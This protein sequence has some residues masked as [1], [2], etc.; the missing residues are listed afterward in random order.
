MV[1]LTQWTGFAYLFPRRYADADLKNV[2]IEHWSKQFEWDQ[3]GWNGMKDFLTEPEVTLE[4]QSGDC[5]DFAFVIV[6]H[7]LAND[8]PVGI[9]A[10]WEKGGITPSHMVAYDK[11]CVY[12]S[13]NIHQS[14]SLDKYIRDS[15]YSWCL[16]RRA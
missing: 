3:D 10:C 12:S 5:E 15:K 8:I 7:H 13:G 16:P 6:S 11:N 9:A 1:K 14:T 2:D 4:E